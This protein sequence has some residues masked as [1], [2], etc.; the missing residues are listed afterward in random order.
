LIRRH[1][2]W[3]LTLLALVGLGVRLFFAFHWF[4]SGDL[5]TFALVGHI[6]DT[7]LLH[8][9]ATNHGLVFWPYPPGYLPVMI[10]APKIANDLGIAYDR[11]IQMVPILADLAIAFAVYVYLGWRNA[12]Q[13][14]RLAGF[15]LVALGPAFIAISGY[16][17]QIDAVA[18]LPAVLA[19]M[20]WERHPSPRRSLESG[21]LIGIGAV[22][23][24]VPLLILLPLLYSARSLRERVQLVGAAGAVVALVCLPFFLAEPSGFR[25]GPLSYSGVPSRG[26]LSL[27]ADPAFAAARRTDISLTFSAEPSA[28][29]KWISHANGPL[30]VLVLVLLAAF[31]YRYRPALIDAMVLLWLAVFVFSPNFLL[32]YLVWALP[33]FIMAGYLKEVAVLQIAM[34]P[35]L[36]ITY[37]TPSALSDRAADLY[38]AMMIGLWVFWVVALVTVAARVA[39]DC[40]RHPDGPRPPLVALASSG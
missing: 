35:A 1:P 30:T 27:V 31:L 2:V 25:H 14:T 39:R 29:A 15:A 12:S 6:A 3:I 22:I 28:I 4:G 33:F 10:E 21:A 17:G 8:T 13:A 24:T 18:I 34:V 32:Q 19:F 20:I 7:D 36:I 37:I 11:V 9:Y 16:H 26:G 23:K 5:I 38:V 40:A